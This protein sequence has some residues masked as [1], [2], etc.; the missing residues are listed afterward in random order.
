M[1]PSV[2]LSII[3]ESSKAMKKRDGFRKLFERKKTSDAQGIR[4]CVIEL[5]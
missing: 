3:E 4:G 2:N 1:I 5:V